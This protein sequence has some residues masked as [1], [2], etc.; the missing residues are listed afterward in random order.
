MDL[1]EIETLSF[2]ITAMF[3]LLIYYVFSKERALD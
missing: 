2:T 1:K 3:I